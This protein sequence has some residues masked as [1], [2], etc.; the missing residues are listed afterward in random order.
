MPQ[1]N[2]NDMDWFLLAQYGVRWQDLVSKAKT[3][4]SG[5]FFYCR[6]YQG[7]FV[8]QKACIVCDIS[9]QTQCSVEGT[10]TVQRTRNS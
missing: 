5:P 4:K 1:I 2:E 9:L 8:A 6:K 10:R 7:S 3:L